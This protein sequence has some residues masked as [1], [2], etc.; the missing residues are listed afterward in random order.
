MVGVVALVLLAEAHVTV[1]VTLRHAS[2][3]HHEEVHVEVVSASALHL[4]VFCNKITWTN[5]ISTTSTQLDN[6]PTM[7]RLQHMKDDRY[8]LICL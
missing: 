4:V 6:Y 8:V 5:E 7:A 2:V 3:V 1:P